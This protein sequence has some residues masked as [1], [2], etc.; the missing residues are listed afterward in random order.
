MDVWIPLQGRAEGLD[1]G[2]HAGSGMRFVDCR[3]H[4]LADGFVGE[5]RELTQELAMV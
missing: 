5:L 2:D 1:D 4:H 3:G